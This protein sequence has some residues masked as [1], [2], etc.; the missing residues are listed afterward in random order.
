VV[1]LADITICAVDCAYPQLA[2]RALERSISQCDFGD[3]ILFSDATVAGPFRSVPISPI[4]SRDA[5]SQFVL[6][7]LGAYVSTAFTLI[8]QWDGWVIN[9]RAW[10]AEFSN[11]DYIGAVW[12]WHTDGNNMGNGGFSLRS[13]KLLAL[14]TDPNFQLVEGYNE[15]ELICRVRRSRLEQRLGVRFAP[16]ALADRF[17]YERRIPDGPTFGFHGLFNMWRH[18]EDM[19]MAD[20]IKC[21]RPHTL[22]SPEIIELWVRYVSLRKF[23]A[24]TH[25]FSRL[26]LSM[27]QDEIRALAQQTLGDPAMTDACVAACERWAMSR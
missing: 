6:K 13:A 25:L 4:T 21:L 10:R 20:I 1:R 8:V 11:Y 9:P 19:E 27:T 24:A 5:Y 7:Q 3:A 12:P 16:E 2:A 23:A 26:R 18:V 22:R 17:A 15:D 14:T